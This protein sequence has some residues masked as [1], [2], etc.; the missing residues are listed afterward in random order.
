MSKLDEE[1]VK[2][3]LDAIFKFAD[4]NQRL[5]WKRKRSRIDKLIKELEPLNEKMLELI[6]QKQPLLDEIESVRQNMVHECVH[7]ID[8]LAHRDRGSYVLCKFC[9]A[10]ISLK[11]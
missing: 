7:P 6:L 1:Q 11:R 8:Y 4:K 10:K 5:S 2:K 9:G 3:D